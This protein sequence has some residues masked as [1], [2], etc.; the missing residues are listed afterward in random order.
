MYSKNVLLFRTK[1]KKKI[2]KSY[3]S[4]VELIYFIIE[5]NNK[6]IFI[7][8]QQYVIIIYIIISKSMFVWQ[9]IGSAP[10]HQ[11][12][13]RP[14]S[15]E[16]VWPEVETFE[17]NFA[18]KWPVD[19]LSKWNVK[20]LMLFYGKSFYIFLS[21]ILNGLWGCISIFSII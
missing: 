17:K 6:K 8:N 12:D 5:F 7:Y 11:R 16:P 18:E 21:F 19:K 15:L 9:A 4:N 13:L 3:E 1:K 14:V 10:G 2:C 20:P